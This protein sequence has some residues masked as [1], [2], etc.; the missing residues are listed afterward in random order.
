MFMLLHLISADIFTTTWISFSGSCMSQR[1]QR[2]AQGHNHTYRQG[3]SP[4][5]ERQGSLWDDLRRTPQLRA[6]G[7]QLCFGHYSPMHFCDAYKLIGLKMKGMCHLMTG[8]PQ[9][10]QTITT[11]N[12]PALFPILACSTQSLP[13]NLNAEPYLTS[14]QERL[15]EYVVLK[16]LPLSV[17]NVKMPMVATGEY[18]IWNPFG[19]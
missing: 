10:H 15:W 1:I 11:P 17:P 6:R 8:V 14:L 12:I 2:R 19:L 5:D 7:V 16:A 4:K 18:I 13:S 3:C 9:Q